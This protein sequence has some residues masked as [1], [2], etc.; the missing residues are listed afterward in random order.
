M[1]S[2]GIVP[3]VFLEEDNNMSLANRLALVTGGARGI[4][5]AIVKTLAR[6]GAQVTVSDL[7]QDACH[8][9]VKA[10]NQPERHLALDIDV[11]KRH[12]VKQVV[13]TMQDKFGSPPDIV[14]NSA[15]I[16]MDTYL[17]K[18]NDETFDKVIEV[19]LKGTFLVNQITA[20]SMKEMKVNHG[21]IVNISSLVG[22]TFVNK[23][24]T[25]CKH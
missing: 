23:Q 11:T 6:E 9:V 25:M 13:E 16:T 4:G 12:S 14:I 24:L 2:V 18:M 10:L 19:N 1:T 8:H 5:A 3:F 17:L 22:K 21:A 7:D 15:G 20:Q